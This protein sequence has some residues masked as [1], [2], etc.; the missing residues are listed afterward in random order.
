MQKT[1]EVS[2]S[3]LG[4]AGC[5]SYGL[6]PIIPA[7]SSMFGEPLRELLAYAPL[8]GEEPNVSL[9]VLGILLSGGVRATK[10]QLCWGI[11]LSCLLEF[12][13]SVLK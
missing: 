9:V 1:L 4:K 10:L 3:P 2:L 11:S 8:E 5:H 13:T 12:T 7:I 6:F